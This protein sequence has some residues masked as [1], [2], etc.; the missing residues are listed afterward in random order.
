MLFCNYVYTYVYVHV[1]I[2]RHIHTYNNYVL[3]VS[4]TD[5]KI[6]NGLM[7]PNSKFSR[8][9]WKSLQMHWTTYEWKWTVCKSSKTYSDYHLIFLPK[10][11]KFFFKF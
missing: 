9:A 7:L 10:K 4:Y 1:Y 6:N 5:A 8:E 3:A 2:H 11:N